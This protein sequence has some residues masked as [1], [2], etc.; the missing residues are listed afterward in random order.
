MTY[1]NLTDTEI[2]A[3]EGQGCFCSD[4][5]E[6]RVRPPFS[7]GAIRNVRFEGQV[8]LG[9][10]DGMVAPAGAAPRPAG[11]Y[12]C[13]LKNCEIQG[14]VYISQV[15]RLEGYLI[16][17]GVAIEQVSSLVVEG[18]TAFGN[19]V[20]AEVLNEGGGREVLLFDQLTAQIAY[21]MA[22][23]RHEPEMTAKLKHLAREYCDNQRSERGVIRAGSYIRD[24]QSV[25]N[26]NFGPHTRA[27]GA[28][29]LEEGTIASCAE[30][31]SVI[32]PGVIARNFIVHSGATVDSG[33]ILEKCFVGQGVRIGKQYSAENTLFFAN[34]EAF[35]GE[36]VSLFAGP[37]TVTHHKS[38]LLIAGMFSFFNAGSGTNQSNHMY[39]L[40]P[41]HQ[42]WLERGCKTGSFSYLLWPSRAGAF[43]VVMDKHSSNFD[44]SDFPFSYLTIE[45][46]KSVLTP[47]M[48]LFTVGVKRDSEKWP[49]RDRR[50]DPDKLDLI[51]FELFSPYLAGKMLRASEILQTLYDEASREQKYVRY[52]GINILRLLLKTCRKYY[53]LALKK[54]YGEQLIQRLEGRSFDNLQALREILRSEQSGTDNWVDVAGLLAPAA[55]I[56]EAVEGLK[57]GR[58]GS[59]EQLRASL[60]A[61]YDNYEAY[62]WAWYIH[63]LEQ[64]TGISIGQATEEQLTGLIREWQAS[65][66][67]LNNMILKDAEKEF[68]LNSRIGFG[69]DGGE[70]VQAADFVAVRG[71]FEENA[72]VRK[73]RAENE[74]IGKKAVFWAGELERIFRTT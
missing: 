71:N 49:A 43:S 24:V 63:T 37:Y 59:V 33:A 73:L 41:L 62:A 45:E 22:N 11:L 29:L 5:N 39:K 7:P 38:S 69:V 70:E 56:Q 53:Q 66:L 32:G 3:L 72:F 16:E 14:P 15:G 20:E 57:G 60:R 36:A 42:G 4:W 46:G 67:K 50:E 2:T 25:R 64:E 40:G 35:H 48:N 30:A 18:Q 68:D 58:I 8:A 52:K 27:C 44:T 13:Y 74:E 61:I 1:R 31:P 17:G 19:G 54:Y 21:L 55:A 47:A 6:V 51:R 9:G 23:Y 10:L 65:A 34:C 28:R 26:V 12:S